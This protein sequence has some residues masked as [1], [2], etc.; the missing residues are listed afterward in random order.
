MSNSFHTTERHLPY[1]IT[2]CYCVTYHA[3]LQVNVT[4]L[5][6]KPDRAVLD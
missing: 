4:H 6:P 1:K 3:K 2:Q 5:N